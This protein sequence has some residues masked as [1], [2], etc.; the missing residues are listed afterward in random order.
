M[1][2]L[3][4]TSFIISRG[5][6]PSCSL[7]LCSHGDPCILQLVQQQF[8]WTNPFLCLQRI[9]FFF[10]AIMFFLQI[11]QEKSICIIDCYVVFIFFGLT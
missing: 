2:R 9:R 11:G 5:L 4:D 3:F 10:V 6:Y 1:K 8:L 7:S